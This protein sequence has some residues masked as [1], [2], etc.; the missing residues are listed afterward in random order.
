MTPQQM[1]NQVRIELDEPSQGTSPYWKNAELMHRLHDSQGYLYRKMVQARDNLFMTSTDI[2]L[3]A[4][5]SAYDLPKNARLG[6]QWA[7][8]ENRISSANPPLYV[9]DVRFQD[10]LMLEGPIGVTDPSDS[11]FAA[12]M[13]RDQ[14]RLSPAPGAATSAGIRF[15]YNPMFGNMHQ[16][17]VAESTATLTETHVPR[18][19]TFIKGATA[20]EAIDRRDDFYNG[21]DVQ[22][23]TDTTTEAA[24]GQERRIT[25][26]TY[27]TT[28]SYG[29]LTHAAWTTQPSAVAVYA[30]KCPIPEDMHDLVV[31]RAS[32][33]AAS[34]RP[35]LLPFIKDKYQD[36]YQEAVGWITTEQSFRGEQVVPSDLGSY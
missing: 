36:A 29:V 28:N 30:V 22:I 18:V 21:M 7:L 15:W 4:S 27:D 11:S 20:E 10:T 31:L 17:T 23:V 12:V 3:V 14:L 34:K 16:G 8:I 13:Q 24:V 35:R 26:Y 25:D 6:T 1:L 5:Q 9:S 33:L 32:M 19:P 2:D